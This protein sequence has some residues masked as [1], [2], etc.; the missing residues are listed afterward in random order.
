MGIKQ[1]TGVLLT[2]PPGTGKT[3]LA[4]AI[5]GEASVP[6]FFVSGSEFDEI[7]V[8]MGARR[9]RKLFEDAR[10]HAPCIV[11]IDEIDAVGLKRSFY[12]SGSGRQTVNQLLNEIGGFRDDEGILVIAATNLKHVLDPALIR[13]GRFDV[14]IQTS[15]PDREARETLLKKITSKSR[16]SEDVNLEVL[17][18]LTIGFSGA[19]LESLINVAAMISV[20]NGSQDIKFEHIQEA[21][22]RIQIGSKQVLGDDKQAI[23]N[24]I[25]HECGHA[26]VSLLTDGTL[27]IGKITIIPRGN[28]LGYVTHVLGEEELYSRSKKQLLASIDVAMGGRAAEEVFFGKDRVTTGAENDLQQASQ[29]A[30]KAVY[31]WGMGSTI[32]VRTGVDRFTHDPL[33][34]YS[35]ATKRK[36]DLEIEEI[37]SESYNRAKSL[38]ENNK[39]ILLKLA[40][41]GSVCFLVK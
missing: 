2:G 7:F 23:R 39:H 8:G 1:P 3:L 27:P 12:S 34:N 4:R 6:F 19:E 20:S 29:M 41:V 25:I 32:R 9:V 13:P 17:S 15:L 5:A 28:A 37:L 26:L 11:F 33:P 30:R 22:D 35:E 36:N 24:T 31:E 16:L 40:D 38:I 14:E 21:L 18:R 10:K